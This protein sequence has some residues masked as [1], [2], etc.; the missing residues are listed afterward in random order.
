[1]LGGIRLASNVKI[2]DLYEEQYL[3]IYPDRL[4]GVMLT[5]DPVYYELNDN[6]E[7]A[8]LILYHATGDLYQYGILTG[9]NQQGSKLALNYMINGEKVNVSSYDNVSTEVGPQALFFEED[10]LV[11]SS[12][13]KDA[14][15]QS[16]GKTSVQVKDKIYP[17][18]DYC[19]VYYLKDGEYIKTTLDKISDLKKYELT[20]YYDKEI[21]LGGRVRI[22]VAKP[23]S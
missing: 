8:K 7:I 10:T 2:L 17:L 4:A 14:A 18:A 12:L 11:Y 3:S 5:L 21:S 13:L 16:V 19:E 15:I 6:R 23:I 22:I 1:M 9:Y 20:A